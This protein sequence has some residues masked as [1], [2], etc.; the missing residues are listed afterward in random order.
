MD[1]PG[2]QNTVIFW[3]GKKFSK[4]EM[5]FVLSFMLGMMFR[6]AGFGPD[7]LFIGFGLTFLAITYFLYAFLPDRGQEFIN[8]FMRKVMVISWAM[9][10]VGIMFYYL[11]Y[12]GF[13]R[14][15]IAGFLALASSLAFLLIRSIGTSG[16]INR[17]DMTRS[18]IILL[19]GIYIFMTV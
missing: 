17:S 18:T 11:E 7:R 16:R 1:Q 8:I 15:L 6:I 2:G 12:P 10:V 13:V 19:T 5:T 14:P 4:L 9:I 3:I